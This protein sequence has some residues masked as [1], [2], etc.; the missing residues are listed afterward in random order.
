MLYDYKQYELSIDEYNLVK[1]GRKI[2]L[3]L[4]EKIVVLKYQNELVGIYEKDG[5][6][7]KARRVWNNE[8]N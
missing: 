3:E 6:L 2:N 8:D 7:Y 4:E 5:S 1:H